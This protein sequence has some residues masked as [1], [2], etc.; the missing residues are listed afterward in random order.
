MINRRDFL[1][2]TFISTFY[3]H[4]LTSCGKKAENLQTFPQGIASGDPKP[5]GITLW[6]R[7]N[8][9]VFDKEYIS[10]EISN[11]PDFSDILVKQ[12]GKI[13]PSKN[14][15]AKFY[16]TSEELLPWSKYYYRFIY[17]DKKSKTGTFKTLPDKNQNVEKI[18]FAVLNCQDYST[19]NFFTHKHLAEENIDFVLF[20]GDYIYEYSYD[21]EAKKVLREIYL[22]SG[23]DVASDIEDY[24][25]LYNTYKSDIYLQEV[26]RKFPFIAVW[27]DHEYANDCYGYHAPDHFIKEEQK[28][29]N[30]RIQANKAWFYNMPVNIPFSETSYDSIK[31]Y[32]SF[33]F[34]NLMKLI[35]TDERLFRSE[36]PCGERKFQRYLIKG[37][38]NE[39]SPGRTMLGETQ[40][41]WFFNQ[42][43]N[44]QIWTVWANPV[45]FMELKLNDYYISFDSWDGYQYERE[46]ILF[47]IKEENIKNMFILTGDLHS[48]VS[49]YPRLDGENVVPEFITTSATSSNLNEILPIDID[50]SFLEELILLENKHIKYFNSSTNGYSIIEVYK[51]YVDITFK[52][53][54]ILN[55]K[56]NVKIEKKF[57]IYSDTGEFKEI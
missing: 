26:H 29:K 51:D 17:K 41:D 31:V 9:Y 16:I 43:D 49:G 57:R 28:L 23:N 36:H 25:Y 47:K 21:K 1:K 27:D 45:S 30:L 39:K 54:D 46:K 38:G 13:E 52:S 40:L 48:F 7:I 10:V 8:P 56:K 6:T 24:Y 19:G 12:T 33:Q 34:G 18:R 37:C 3:P 53:V 50:V 14:Y 2:L 11:R 42:L 20:L 15:T 4:I 32:R 44:Y 55:L 5:N 22:P 35:L